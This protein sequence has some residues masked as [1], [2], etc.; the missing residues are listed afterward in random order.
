MLDE[1]EDNKMFG[2]NK[3]ERDLSQLL[4]KLTPEEKQDLVAKLNETSEGE[5]PSET[6]PASTETKVVEEDVDKTIAEK[7]KEGAKTPVEDTPA[8]ETE[9]PQVQE[10]QPNAIPI[11]NVMLKSDFEKYIQDFEARLNGVKKENEQLQAENK[12]LAQENEELKEKYE[13]GSFGN[14]NNRNTNSN[15]E[16]PAKESYDE[17]MKKFFNK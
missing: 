1:R 3:K 10:E 14:Y 5:K 15:N 8:T 6:T 12:Q 9:Q 13:N 2:K 16:K 17:Y 11:E 7:G 4:E